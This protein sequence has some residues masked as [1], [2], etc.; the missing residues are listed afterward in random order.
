[1]VCLFAIGACGLFASLLPLENVNL[2]RVACCI[3]AIFVDGMLSVGL[4][5]GC[6]VTYPVPANNV[7][8]V[9]LS[10]SHML[11]TVAIFSASYI[12]PDPN[13]DDITG[14]EAKMASLVM[15]LLLLVSFLASLLCTLLSHEDLRKT[16]V[17]TE[18]ATI[19]CVTS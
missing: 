1:M 19:D 4:E 8:G 13:D 15:C 9:I 14:F 16:K 6:E 12:L 2:I 3:L 18:G 11:S 17:D 5:Y 10:Y 7:S